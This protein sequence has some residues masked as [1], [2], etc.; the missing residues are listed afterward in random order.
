MMMMMTMTMAM[1][2]MVTMVMM[3]MGHTKVCEVG[4]S[5]YEGVEDNEV[6]SQSVD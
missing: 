5:V 6:A 3:T 4:T 2:M 1:M